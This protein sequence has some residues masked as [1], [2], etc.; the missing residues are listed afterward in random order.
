LH[1]L[2]AGPHQANGPVAQ[3]VC[4]PAGTDRDTCVAEQSR[5]NDAIGL[6]GKARVERTEHKDKAVTS[7]PRQP[8]RR[9]AAPSAG[10]ETPEAPCCI[11]ACGEIR[12]ERNDDRG[13]QIGVCAADEQGGQSAVTVI[14]DPM[15]AVDGAARECWC[16][17]ADWTG[18]SE[19]LRRRRDENRAWIE[20]RQPDDQCAVRSKIRM[21]REIVTPIAR[22]ATP[23]TQPDRR[24]HR[25]LFDNRA[26]SSDFAAGTPTQARPA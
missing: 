21:D 1:Q 18:V 23:T 24:S 16:E 4:L 12:I 9:T 10:N 7:L 13:W 25:R 8:I 6:A 20:M 15:F 26:D 22:S 14:E 11:G 2:R 17:Q 3:V 19:G 5:R